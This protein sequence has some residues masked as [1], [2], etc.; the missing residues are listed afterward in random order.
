MPSSPTLHD[1][2]ALAGVSVSTVSRVLNE[3]DHVSAEKRDRVKAAMARLDYVGNMAARSLRGA[4]TMTWVL[5]VDDLHSD[6]FS[7]LADTLTLIAL[8]RGV[9]LL[10]GTT[11]K[12]FRRERE[13]LHQ[14]RAR[15]VDGVFVVAAT[16][17]DHG[18]RTLR[19]ISMPTVYIERYPAGTRGDIVTF[20]YYRA[21]LEQIDRF[22]SE[23]HRRI[24]LLGGN[25]AEDPGSRRL[26]AYLDGLRK[27][28]LEPD[29]ALISVGH[30]DEDDGARG[31][32]ELLALAD[33]PTAL[34]VTVGPLLRAALKISAE[35]RLTWSICSYEKI[36][37][38]E[39]TPVPITFLQGDLEALARRA[40][41]M[42]VERI[43]APEHPPQ[44]ELL[45]LSMDQYWP[46]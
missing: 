28:G 22:W 38:A 27:H 5:L 44:V 39:L 45:D 35:Q 36:D 33:P 17:D 18:E 6:F 41:A 29:P 12:T 40:A 46:K 4:P 13:I 25:T 1:V 9:T 19:P 8:E 2:A 21:G 32:L 7:E 43:A 3:A 24:G 31:V 20:D 42:L 23:G 30:L 15:Q 34:M 37:L 16:G 11:Q 14:V 10:I 26:S